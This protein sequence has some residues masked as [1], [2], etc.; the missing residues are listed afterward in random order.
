MKGDGTRVRAHYR[1]A[2]GA[3]KEMA[4]FAVFALAVAGMGDGAVDLGGD[5]GTGRSPRPDQSV[6]YPIKFPG[7][8]GKQKQKQKPEPNQSV[9]YPIRFTPRAGEQ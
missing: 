1:W 3:R 7:S 8:S 6:Q 9:S 5:G 2:A 4:I